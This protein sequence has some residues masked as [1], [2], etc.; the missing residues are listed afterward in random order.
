MKVYVA[1]NDVFRKD[2]NSPI[3]HP[4]EF[5]FTEEGGQINTLLGS[6][7]AM[8]LWH[9]DLKIG[10]MCH[11]ILPGKSECSADTA[12][13][14][15]LNGRYADEAILLFERE[16]KRC[17]TQLIEYQA[18]IF[19]GSN[20]LANYSLT[21]D[22]QIGNMNTQAAIKILQDRGIP[23]LVAHVGESGHRNIVFDVD[24]GDV[25]VKHVPLQKIIP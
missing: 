8:T 19:G 2:V 16:A 15:I 11:F 14:E 6:C 22:K 5:Y 24:T 1:N 25:W 10:G 7:I 17:G 18:K 23:L 20:M 3:L 9:P 4:G 12:D 13:N 21:Q